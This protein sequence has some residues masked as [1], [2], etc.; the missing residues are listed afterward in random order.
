MDLDNLFLL[1]LSE[2]DLKN[3]IF[4][5]NKI[6]GQN[7]SSKDRCYDNLSSDVNTSDKFI[8]RNEF[9]KDR[10]RILFSKA[11]RRLEHKAQ[12]YSHEKGDHF[13]TRLTHTL[14]VMQIARSI[15]KNL[16]L[17]EDLTEAIALGHDIGHT[18]F[19]HTGEQ[20]LND[21][22]RG[23][24]SLGNKISFSLDYG[25][26][27]HNF[28]SLKILDV[29]EKK[30]D[31]KRGLNLTWQVLE[32]ILKHTKIKKESESWE[33]TRFMD[34]S[35]N[36]TLLTRLMDMEDNGRTF[37]VTLEGQIVDVADE[38]AQRQHDLDDGLRDNDLRLDYNEI[39]H[40]LCSFIDEA[41]SE[42][43]DNNF[44]L[45][46]L[47]QFKGN[48]QRRRKSQNKKY[49][50][51]ALIRDVIDYFI[52]DVTLNSLKNIY[53]NDFK[54]FEKLE[55]KKIVTKRLICLSKA[56][57]KIDDKIETYVKNQILNSYNVNRFD[58]KA[59]FI[60]RQLFKAYY[61]NPRQMP[62]YRLKMLSKIIKKNSKEIYS[63]KFKS[64]VQT[65][66]IKNLSDINFESSDPKF[67]QRL[68]NLLKLEKLDSELN[69]LEDPSNLGHWLYS[70]NPK[71]K[72]YL[73]E[74]N[75]RDLEQII[76]KDFDLQFSDWNKDDSLLMVKCLLENHY[77]YLSVICD[78]IAGMTDNFANNEFKKLYLV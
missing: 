67:I 45:V 39:L 60:I 58:G 75:E 31:A 71:A 29:I 63:I 59:I 6:Y 78:Y 8:K 12:V 5:I 77:A 65:E 42:I 44:E 24:D 66:E 61:S 11:F 38:I 21:V 33:L 37:S 55:D 49:K 22:M 14:E 18:P 46:L 10:D 72:K 40:K 53:D 20:I 56:G 57:E 16:G 47:E 74:I 64:A 50:W 1:D 25:G 68:I 9:S 73:S 28:Y 17:N 7:P 34:D 3:I 70:E 69:N 48:I 30:Y 51:N 15:S 23:R 32:G 41:I 52:R 54:C 2:D 36:K 13:R 4:R 76:N 27:K 43:D 35:R 19:G 26:F 62:K